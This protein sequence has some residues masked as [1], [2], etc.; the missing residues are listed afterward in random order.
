MKFFLLF[1]GIL[2]II[3]IVVLYFQLFTGPS[4]MIPFFTALIDIKQFTI[5]IILLAFGAGTFLTI[6]IRW[7]ISSN[8]SIDD[9][10]NL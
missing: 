6:S 10:F 9:D 4:A 5:Y 8:D 2:F 7:F 1:M 3:A